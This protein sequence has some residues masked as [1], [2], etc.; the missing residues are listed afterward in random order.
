MTTANDTV[1]RARIDHDTKDEATAILAEIGLTPSDAFRMLLRRTVA[2]KA[3]PFA[4][5][6]PNADTLAAIAEVRQGGRPTYASMK[7]LRAALDANA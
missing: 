6:V 5:L 1:V 3:L 7:E 4:P 2:E